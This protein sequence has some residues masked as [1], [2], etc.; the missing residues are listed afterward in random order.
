[1]K[2]DC[3]RKRKTDIH[4]FFLVICGGYMRVLIVNFVCDTG[5][6]GRICTGLANEYIAKGDEVKIAYGRHSVMNDYKIDTYHIGNEFDVRF[7]GLHTRLTDRHGFANKK[8]TRRFIKWA[9]EYD[10]DLL[11]LHNIHGYYI[12]VEILFA[13]IKSRPNMQVKWT[14]HDCW[15]FTGHCTH[16]TDVKCEQWKTHCSHC[17]QKS[18]YPK[19]ILVDNCYNNYERKMKAFC[20]VRKM[21]IIT[22][23]NWLATIVKDSFLNKY[24]IEVNYNKIDTEVFKPTPSDFR[25]KFGLVEKKIILGVANVWN[26]KKGLNDFY[27]L[28]EMLD[29]RYWIVLVGLNERQIKQLPARILGIKHTDS[30]RELA[31]IYSA[32]D[33]FVNPS[34]EETYG[35]TTVEAAACG[36]KAIVYKGTACEEVVNT[37]HCGTAVEQDIIAIY[38]AILNS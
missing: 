25:I 1:M 11:W 36:T 37:T 7:S 8:S 28:R 30:I 19:S 9:T 24:P 12:N 13:W 6:T 5:S 34:K 32:A 10:P 17:V 4:Y 20:G 18:Q 31:E 35:M 33:I 38:N 14:L 16:F 23:S 26:E 27:K 29:D 21:T 3:Q 22:P 15:A 2:K